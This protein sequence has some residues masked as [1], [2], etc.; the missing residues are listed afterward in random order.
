MEI[1]GVASQ[2]ACDI[3]G[4]ASIDAADDVRTDL[5]LGLIAEVLEELGNL[6]RLL[7]L[8]AVAETT[9]AITDYAVV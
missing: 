1:R 4:L 9:Q 8:T 6:D 2:S 5:L 3:E 7:G